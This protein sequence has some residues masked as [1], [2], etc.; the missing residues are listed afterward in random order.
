[1]VAGADDIQL[2]HRIVR[3]GLPDAAA[4]G[5]PRAG[6]VFPALA[7]GIA[8][9]RHGVEAPDLVAGLHVERGDPPAGSRIAGAVLDTHFPVGD[10]RRRVDALL[11]AAL[12]FL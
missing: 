10:D 11:A 9:L 7:A 12:I 1:R 8:G 5:F 4:A 3:T 6:V 2:L